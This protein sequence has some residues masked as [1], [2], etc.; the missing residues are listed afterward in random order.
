[1]LSLLGLAALGL[2]TGC[3]TSPSTQVDKLSAQE[4]AKRARPF[5]EG[6]SMTLPT[7]NTATCRLPTDAVIPA[8]GGA[9]TSPTS[10]TEVHSWKTWVL[11]G[12]ACVRDQKWPEVLR[13][14][15][16]L[17][18]NE[19]EAPWGPYFLSLHAQARGES[20]RAHWL[21]DLA[22]KKAGGEMAVVQYERARQSLARGEMRAAVSHLKSAVAMDAELAPAQL[23]LAQVHEREQLWDEAVTHY[24]AYLKLRPKSAAA[25][26]AYAEVQ[27]QRQKPDEAV[28][29]LLRAIHL[30]PTSFK[31]RLKLATVY[32]QLLK[33]PE[34]SLK[35]LKEA[36]SLASDLAPGSRSAASKS[37]RERGVPTAPDLQ[38]KI[39]QI[40]QRIRA[41]EDLVKARQPAQAQSPRPSARQ[42]VPPTQ[43]STES[44]KGG[45]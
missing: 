29:P 18:R 3:A 9:K 39:Q 19:I 36:R 7:E 16:W 26:F 40:D 22:E 38:L 4:N 13:I 23:W 1:M 24:A 30:E 42:A 27:L 35:V 33:D 45:G 15:E 10:G 21:L 44:E 37:N 43:S 5:I 34:S 14:G 17:S 2:I 8:R 28:E 6:A 41:L 20:S 25:H 12:G 31:T 11:A 32:E